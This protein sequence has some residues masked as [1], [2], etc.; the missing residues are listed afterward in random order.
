MKITKCTKKIANLC[1]KIVIIQF[2]SRCQFRDFNDYFHSNCSNSRTVKC[3]AP[4]I[5]SYLS[6]IFALSADVY[7]VIHSIQISKIVPKHH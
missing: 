5:N 6:V 4:E 3:T 1:M 2:S 7:Y